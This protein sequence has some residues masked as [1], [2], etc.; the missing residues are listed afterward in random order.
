MAGE[1]L[2]VAV[3]CRVRPHTSLAFAP[4]FRPH[5]H[6]QDYHTRQAYGFMFSRYQ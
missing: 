4:L 3:A 1:A 2:H 6:P 5:H